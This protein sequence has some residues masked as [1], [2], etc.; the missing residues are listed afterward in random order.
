MSLRVMA[1]LKMREMS[2][3]SRLTEAALRV[4]PRAVIDFLR[5]LLNFSMSRGET[6]ARVLP[7]K[8]VKS[9]RARKTS[10]RHERFASFA[11]TR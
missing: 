1:R 7:L 5:S 6:C 11:Q 2:S 4:E 10:C 9:T 3:N 8:C